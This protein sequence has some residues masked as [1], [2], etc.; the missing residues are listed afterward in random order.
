MDVVDDGRLRL[1]R[2]DSAG[3][4]GVCDCELIRRDCPRPVQLRRWARI[5]KLH[6][7]HKMLSQN[8]R[9]H[10]KYAAH[11]ALLA[12]VAARNMNCRHARSF[13]ALARMAHLL[14]N[15][16]LIAFC[17]SDSALRE[18]EQR[19]ERWRYIRRLS[20]HKRPELWRLGFHA[21]CLYRCS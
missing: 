20:N 7:V 12:A 13:Y 15:R 9:P 5:A 2:S 19:A 21:H 10:T 18:H 11:F 3:R 6:Y 14:S 1:V 8:T 16:G 4:E 17:R